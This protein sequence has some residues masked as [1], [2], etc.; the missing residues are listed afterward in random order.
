ML[1]FKNYCWNLKK[2]KYKDDKNLLKVVN[3]LL[4]NNDTV[5]EPENVNRTNFV[6]KREI[7]HSTLYSFNA[8]FQLLHAD[9]AN[10]EFLG[11]NATFRQYVL[12]IVDLFSSKVYTYR[13]NQENKL[14]RNLSSFIEMLTAKEKVKKWDCK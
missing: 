12:V 9:I 10:L 7:D 3:N 5:F 8:P 6:E 1:H 11:K 13:W 2:S 14:D 4:L